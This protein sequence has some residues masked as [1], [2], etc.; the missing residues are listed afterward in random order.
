MRK[1]RHKDVKK[2]PG[3]TNNYQQSRNSNLGHLAPCLC[4]YYYS[5]LCPC[6]QA[7]EQGNKGQVHKHRNVYP[8]SSSKYFPKHM[9]YLISDVKFLTLMWLW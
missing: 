6:S 8:Y 2:A 7:G 4:C 9:F 5:Y 1:L 3:H